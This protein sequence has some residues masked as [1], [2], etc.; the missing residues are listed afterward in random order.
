MAQLKSYDIVGAKDDV[1]QIMS[2]ISPSS[3]PFLSAIGTR[4]VTQRKFEWLED[5]L[6]SSV[7]NN[8]L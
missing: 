7:A 2:T 3:T 6:R 1:S 8:A 5:S 4:K